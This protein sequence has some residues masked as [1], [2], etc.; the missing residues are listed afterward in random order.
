MLAAIAEYDQAWSVQML[1]ELYLKAIPRAE[2]RELQAAVLN[3]LCDRAD[4]FGPRNIATRFEA[5]TARLNLDRAR[6]VELLSIAYGRLLSVEWRALGR[7]ITDIVKEIEQTDSS[8]LKLIARMRGLAFVLLQGDEN[9]AAT[10]FSFYKA[11][12]NTPREWLW[13]RIVWPQVLAGVAATDQTP[14]AVA[15]ARREATRIMASARAGGDTEGNADEHLARRVRTSVREAILPPEVLVKMLDIPQLTEPEPWL[16]VDQYAPLLAD[17]FVAEHRGAVLAMSQLLDEP[18][19]IWPSLKPVVGPPLKRLSVA[20]GR[21]LEALLALSLRIEDEAY[22]LRALEQSP[23]GQSPEMEGRI[24][25]L[26]AGSVKFT[27]RA[28]EEHR[29]AHLVA[30]ASPWISTCTG[31]R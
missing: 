21:A 19:R 23:P 13:T 24:V 15:Y 4:L 30:T 20:G 26:P 8:R 2:S 10:A 14:P 1:I 28:K 9:D 17:A 7:G 25:C 31:V 29:G 22:V 27:V 3:T 12:G 16:L 5:A 11:E 18:N 6:N